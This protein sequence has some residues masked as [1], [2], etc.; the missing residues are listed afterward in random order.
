ME[1]NHYIKIRPAD[2]NLH[3]IENS[4][5]CFRISEIS[6]NVWEVHAFN[7]RLLIRQEGE[8]HDYV[9][10]CSSEEFRKIW[11]DYF[12][13]GR[14]Y[15]KIKS[16]LRAIGDPYL[17][18]AV[19]YGYGI[20]ILR[21]DLWETIVTFLI[22]QQNNISR[23]KNTIVKLCRPYDD[24]FPTPD[25]LSKYTEN[26]F[27]ALGLG[28]RAKY[29]QNIVKAVRENNLNLRELKTMNSFEAINFLKSFRGIGDKVANCIALFGLHK[30]DAFPIDVWIKR[31]IDERY[32]GNFDK[33]RFSEYAGIV[34][35]YMF[36]YR[37]NSGKN[38]DFSGRERHI[39]PGTLT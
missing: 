5:Q 22:S 34:Q 1:K 30:V 28:Y 12:D 32:G 14:D 13:M 21:Q 24:R 9:F 6:A 31:I 3:Q 10:E 36:F 18:A 8:R 7:K 38:I 17:T 37:R 16:N 26:D 29:L 4:G 15:G 27:L 2:F 19:D 35:Q 25:L 39:P 11:F 23:I 33:T 20:R